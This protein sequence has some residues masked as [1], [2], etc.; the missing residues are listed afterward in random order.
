MERDI[1]HTQKKERE[2]ER[3]RERNRKQCPRP[4]RPSI[5]CWDAGGRT[6]VELCHNG[7]SSDAPGTLSCPVQQTSLV[8]EN[9]PATRQCTARHCSSVHGQD[10]DE[11]LKPSTLQV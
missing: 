11:M 5:L 6:K 4:L 3:E 1:T 2:R 10:L 8:E 7:K 9:Y